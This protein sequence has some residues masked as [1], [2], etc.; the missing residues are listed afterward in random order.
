MM[1]WSRDKH[2]RYSKHIDT[3]VRRKLNDLQI[4]SLSCDGR[5]QLACGS[6]ANVI[7]HSR[8]I[9]Y[10]VEKRH[11]G[12]ALALARPC[13]EAFVRGSWLMWC[14]SDDDVLRISS[15]DDFPFINKMIDAIKI[16]GFGLGGLE[17][18]KEKAWDEWCSYTHGGWEQIRGQL[19]TKGLLSPN[20][21]PGKVECT[22]FLSDHWYLLTAAL[23]SE[24]A[25][26]IS[27]A[28]CFYSLYE[29]YAEFV[30]I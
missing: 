20:Y 12:S 26:N 19:S 4:P 10:L 8:A 7:G 5:V 17:S 21:D 1:N 6:W 29:A 2:V 11:D 25:D 14:S 9:T 28:K 16:T 13:F 30:E 3:E 22:L 27:L 18:I 24:A 15:T 23:L